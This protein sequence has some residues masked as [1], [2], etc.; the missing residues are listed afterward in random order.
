MTDLEAL[1]IEHACAKL[2]SRYCVCADRGDIEGFVELFTPDASITIPEYPAFVGHDAIRASMVALV[3]AGLTMRHITTNAVVTP[4][5]A[6]TATGLCYLTVYNSSE[7]ANE[8]GGRPINLPA[9]VGEYED[10]FHHTGSGWRFAAR[11]LTR[12]F[13]KT[14]S[15]QIKPAAQ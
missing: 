5:N 6:T 8:T 14:V 15:S 1:L 3:A 13:Q 2:Q 12:V 11:T 10:V 7:A 9:T 4:Q